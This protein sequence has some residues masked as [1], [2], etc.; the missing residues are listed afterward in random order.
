MAIRH[1]RGWICTSVIALFC[2]IASPQAYAAGRVALVVGNSAY[3]RLP[4]LIN[5]SND[6]VDVSQSFERLGFTV[7][8]IK[9]ASFERLRVALLE[10]GRAAAGAD[11]AVLFYAGHGIEVSGENWLVPID[12]DLKSDADVN[13]EAV[14]LHRAMLSVSNAKQLGLVILDACRSNVFK[15]IRRTGATRAADRGLA[16]I[17]PA[18]NVLVAYAARDGTT[19]ADGKGRNSPFTSALLRHM[20]TPGLELEFLF[21]NVRDDVWAATNGEQQPFLYGSLSKDEIY[22]KA[23][24]APVLVAAPVAPPVI[25]V[26]PSVAPQVVAAAPP[27]VVPEEDTTDASDI[28]WAFLRTTS[29]A[30]TLRRFTEQFPTSNRVQD[31]KIR[32]AALETEQ[33]KSDAPMGGVFMLASVESVQIEE[34]DLKATRPFRRNTPAIEAA[35]NVVKDSKDTT[36]VRRFVD[37]FPSNRRRAAIDARPIPV[38]RTQVAVATPQTSGNTA[39][40]IITRD[41]MLRAAEDP[42][43][44]QCF[45]IDDMAAPECRNAL[46]RYPLIS[47]FT[48]DYRFRFTLCQSLGDGC[49]GRREMLRSSFDLNSKGLFN[50]KN[51]DPAVLANTP[52]PVLIAPV[53]QS[54]VGGGNNVPGANAPVSGPVAN[55]PGG[56]PAG[57]NPAGVTFRSQSLNGP[58]KNGG[59]APRLRFPGSTRGTFASLGKPGAGFKIVTPSGVKIHAKSF[60]VKSFGAKSFGVRTANIGSAHIK[61]VNIRSPTIKVNIHSPNIKTPTIRSI[62]VKIV[63][64]KVPTVKVPTVRVPTVR[65]PTV[66]I[67]R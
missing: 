1:M 12:A 44:L 17:D 10:F 39:P 5:P 63:N 51:A 36:V 16:P 43:V 52:G 40:V 34:E 33:Q 7:T 41:A 14:S 61:G 59:F 19:A 46:E 35:W 21:R 57:G 8:T 47:Q 50:P 49:G 67:P 27:A 30:D 56:N 26:D 55:V 48:Y 28:A 64:I 54:S 65:V 22:F 58:H 23:A 9:D 62:N 18:E 29:D 20:E 2:L 37:H 32:I 45:R 4:G 60:G 31:A 15:N 66:R 3:Q 42:D 24:P 25:V 11:M 53:N 13:T 6:S 38:A